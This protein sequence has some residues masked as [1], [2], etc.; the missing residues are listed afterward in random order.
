VVARPLAGLAARHDV[1][2]LASL[3]ETPPPPM[4][5]APLSPEERADLARYLLATAP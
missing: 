1:A 5:V 3:L 4:P 2:S